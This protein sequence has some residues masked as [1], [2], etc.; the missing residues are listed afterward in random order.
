[1]KCYLAAMFNADTSKEKNGKNTHGIL[2]ERNNM[3]SS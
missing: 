1:M 3:E 2:T